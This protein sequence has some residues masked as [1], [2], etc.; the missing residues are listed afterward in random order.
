MDRS[1]AAQPSVTIRAPEQ[2]VTTSVDH[3]KAIELAVPSR[4]RPE[5]RIVSSPDPSEIRLP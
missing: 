1:Y 3:A 4:L 2:E 5:T